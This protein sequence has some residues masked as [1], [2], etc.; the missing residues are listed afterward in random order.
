[1]VKTMRVFIAVEITKEVRYS[2]AIAIKFLENDQFADL[3][4]VNS[5][6]LHLTLK[7]LGEVTYDSLQI[8]IKAMFHVVPG[9]SAI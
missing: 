5:P 9:A 3:K 4:I 2:L 8:I 6:A 7:F 1:M